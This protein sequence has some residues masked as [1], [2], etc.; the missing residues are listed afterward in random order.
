MTV[1][2][3]RIVSNS[4]V[5]LLLAVNPYYTTLGAVFWLKKGPIFSQNT[6]NDLA[7]PPFSWHFP[8]DMKKKQ[9]IMSLDTMFLEMPGV[10][11]PLKKYL[12]YYCVMTP[13]TFKTHA[14]I[15]PHHNVVIPPGVSIVTSKGE[16]TREFILKP[17]HSGHVKLYRAD[18]KITQIMPKKVAQIMDPVA[19]ARLMTEIDEMTPR[20]RKIEARKFKFAQEDQEKR[21]LAEKQMKTLALR[22]EAEKIERRCWKGTKKE[23]GLMLEERREAERAEKRRK[24]K[25]M[26]QKNWYA[27]KKLL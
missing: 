6:P 5:F 2:V 27:L 23:F 20:E 17:G 7:L 21:Y 16:N 24:Q 8:A 11:F 19:Y 18:D 12:G 26:A 22:K 1:E 3:F 4:G 14:A 10:F 9:R 13:R 15:N 25:N